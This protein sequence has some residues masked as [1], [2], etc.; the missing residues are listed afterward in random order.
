MSFVDVHA[1]LDYKD[2]DNDL[3]KV[4]DNARKAGV[5]KIICNGV[6]Q[7]SNRKV[8]EISKKYDIVDA[9]IG[10][11]PPDA[12]SEEIGKE[13]KI[14][15]DEELKFFEENL[16]KIICIGEI[17][18]DYKNV[19][20]KELQKQIFIKQVEFAKKHNLPII[21]HSRQAEDDVIDILEK[22]NYKKVILHCFSG[23]KS[24]VKK[25]AELGFYFSIPTHVV[26]SE[27]MQNIVREVNINK[28]LT[29]T[30]SPFLSPFKGKRNE[31]AFVV[32]SVKKI[33]EI[34]GFE[35]KEVENNILMNFINLFG[36]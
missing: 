5:K 35:F 25:G 12:L 14:D 21:V 6:S 20:D 28:L 30:D 36:K 15:I 32:E 16:E 26:R 24:L 17:G 13:V 1:H 19:K 29:E 22:I 8:L 23:K 7:E 3:D 27:T 33:A 2:F 34:K 9:G 10:I 4:I 31:P 18:L 11:Y